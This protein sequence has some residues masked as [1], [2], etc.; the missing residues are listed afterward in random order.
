MRSIIITIRLLLWLI[1]AQSVRA[2]T[3]YVAG[4]VT[5]M[6]TPAGSPCITTGDIFVPRGD[7]LEIE[8]GVSIIL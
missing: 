1:F 6:W 2:D 8:A 4:A 3:T 5:G 7:I